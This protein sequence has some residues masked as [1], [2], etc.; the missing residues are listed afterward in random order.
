M[1]G[2]FR[3][4]ASLDRQRRRYLVHAFVRLGQARL[5]LTRLSAREIVDRAD[6]VTP[7]PPHSAPLDLALVEWA[8]TAVSGRAPWRADCLVQAMAA[9]A[10]LA[11]HGVPSHLRLGVAKD[12]R[13][14][15][16]AHAWLIHDG[17][18][19]VGGAIDGAT[20]YAILP[21]STETDVQSQP[22]KR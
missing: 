22:R 7:L 12:E 14:D 5:A 6:S 15:L 9:R 17:K 20:R 16:I 2:T 1:I 3:K 10:W 4:F 18:A 13:G 11:A 19:V 8:M 21:T